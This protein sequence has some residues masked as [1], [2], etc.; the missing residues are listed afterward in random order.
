[1]QRTG[2][3]ILITGAGGNL[4]KVVVRK[5]AEHGYRVLTTTLPGIHSD[6][7]ESITQEYEVDL[8]NEEAVS[9]MVDMLFKDH[10]TLDAALL[11]AGG[12]MPGTLDKTSGQD[13]DKMFSMNFETAY[14]TARAVLARMMEQPSGGRIVLIGARPALEAN[15]GKNAIAYA[16]S[17]SLVFKLAELLNAEGQAKKVITT[18]IVPGTIDTSANRKSMPEAD[19]SQWVSPEEI[20]ETMLFLCSDNA[21]SW[22]EPVIN[23]YGGK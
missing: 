11:L 13:L 19:F 6:A 4:G 5:F 7:N 20:A 9:S 2:K 16:L 23:V 1:M 8:A 10:Q 3:N 21:N 12:F 14:F 18:V 17:K 22:R 15:A